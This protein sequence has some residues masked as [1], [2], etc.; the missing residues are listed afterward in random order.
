MAPSSTRA[1]GPV[2]DYVVVGSGAGGGP[3]A[4]A[5]ARAGFEVL[6]LEAGSDRGSQLVY[7]VPVFHG[8]STEDEAMRWD[9]FV[10]H[11]EDPARQK[12]DSK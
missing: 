9:Y 6:L 2:Y 11:Y 10:Q 8:L 3:V 12:A 7:Q 5:L 4:A 1:D